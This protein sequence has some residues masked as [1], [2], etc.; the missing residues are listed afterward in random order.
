MKILFSAQD[1]DLLRCCRSLLEDDETRVDTAFDG[2]QILT[3]LRA[4]AYDLLIVFEDVP[5]IPLRQIVSYCN[6]A[7]LPVLV[8]TNSNIRL[9]ALLDTVLANAYLP[10]PF[11]SAELKAKIAQIR[12]AQDASEPLHLEGTDVDAAGFAIGDRRMTAEELDVLRALQDGRSP[13][14]KQSGVCIGAINAK[15]AALGSPQ[16]IRYRKQTGY[17]MVTE[18]E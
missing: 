15:L 10:L 14:T 3:K 8:L 16:R 4:E 2:T 13:D 7:S 17:R 9:S 5:R 18:H 1:R 12:A 11:T 6:E